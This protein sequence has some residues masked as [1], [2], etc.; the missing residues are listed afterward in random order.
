MT[1]VQVRQKV[2][3]DELW[4]AILSLV[5]DRGVNPK[6]DVVTEVLDMGLRHFFLLYMI[7]NIYIYIL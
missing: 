6:V 5:R 1:Y 2:F 7:Y 4:A 3:I